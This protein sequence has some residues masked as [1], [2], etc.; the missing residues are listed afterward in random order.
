VFNT[1][2]KMKHF[3]ESGMFETYMQH[4]G[5][6]TVPPAQAPTNLP[7][8]AENEAEEE[9]EAEEEVEEEEETE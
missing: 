6:G 7:E 8:P 1:P 2:E 9:K 4:Y 3:H 5:I